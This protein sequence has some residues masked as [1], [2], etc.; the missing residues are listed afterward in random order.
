[1]VQVLAVEVML[2]SVVVED[3]ADGAGAPLSSTHYALQRRCGAG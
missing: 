1:M 2:V 3:K